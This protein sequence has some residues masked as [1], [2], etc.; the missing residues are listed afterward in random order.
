M[1]NKLYQRTAIIA[2]LLLLT[3]LWLQLPYEAAVSPTPKHVALVFDDGPFPN[4]AP[5]LVELLAKEQV[6]ATF[7]FVASNVHRY[8]STAKAVIAAGHEIAN[9][10]CTHCHPNGLTD[11]ELEKEIV[12]GQTL[13]TETTGYVPRWYWPPFLETDVRMPE[14]ATKA[15]IEI[16]ALNNVID[17]KDHDR[18]I[19]GSRIKRYATRNVTDGAVIVF[20]EWREETREQLP[21]ILAELRRQN[22]VFLTFSELAEKVRHKTAVQ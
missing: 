3:G 14:L 21:A 17:S 7:S 4:H 15:G 12:G 16:Y 20:H 2:V 22:C 6:R 19:S 11:A 1:K 8:E 13:I 18:S 5:I 9:H 10:S